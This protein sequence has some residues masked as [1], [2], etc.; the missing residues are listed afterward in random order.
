MVKI[1]IV[2]PTFNS[3][4]TID[5][6]MQAILEQ[7]YPHDQ[8]ELIFADGGSKDGTLKRFEE[9]SK[10]YDI[11][12]HVYRNPLRTAEAGKAVGVRKAQ[13]DIICLLDSD[14]IIP[15]KSWLSR[16]MKPF[17]ENEIVASE[18]IKYT[19]RR[20]DSV[21]NRYCALIGM[22]D[23]LCI[24]TG[25]YDRYCTITGKWTE[26]EREE[27]DKGD[28][29]SIKFREDMIPT[30]GANGFFM[31]RK[32]LLENF[33]G[34]YLF[35]IDVLWELFRKNPNLRVAKVKTGIVH[36][37]CPDTKTFW[38]KQNRRVKDFLY[39]S[40]AKGRKYPWGKV[41]KGRIV[42]FVICC[43]TII[44]LFIQAAVGYMRKHDLQ[45]WAYHFIACWVTL[46]VYGWGVISG[47]FKKEQADRENWK[48]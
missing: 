44:P 10:R 39:F 45:A 17:E 27:V 42:L 22:N 14:N 9:Y 12:V 33:E 24:F 19:Y 15:D 3:M 5:E 2:T 26:V 20:E 13:G 7:D 46:W 34:D 35:D 40:E 16:M 38:R 37:F 11:P 8:M 28:Y 32:E 21:I 6:Y 1:S 31:R 36:L 47:I 23:P 18:P 48:Q 25:N 43:I 29:L 4:R 30:I 41:A